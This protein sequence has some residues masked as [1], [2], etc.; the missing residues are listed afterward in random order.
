MFP[1]VHIYYHGEVTIAPWEWTLSVLYVVMLY[2]MFAR[3]KNLMLARA[4]EYRY[5]LWGLMAKLF[6]GVVFSL[7]YFYYYQGG[8]TTAYFYSAVAMRNM[9][10]EDPVEY[11]RQLFGDNSLRAW[12]AYTGDTAKPYQYVF[13]DNRTFAVLQFTSLLAILTFKSYLITTLLIASFSFYGVWACFR[14]FVSYYPQLMD[15]LAIGFLFMPS[16]VF[17]GSAILK[18]T[19]SFSAVCFWVHAVDEV[20]YKRR[21]VVK[22]SIIM[23]LSGMVMIVVKPYIFMVLLPATI[24]WLFY[25]RVVRLRSTLV[26]FVLIPMAAASMLGL[27]LLILTRL[28]DQLDKFALDGALQTIQ[29]TQQDLVNEQAYGANRFDVGQI[30]GTW[31]SVLSKFPVATNAALFR[32]YI[33]ESKNAVMMLSGLENLWVLMIAILAVVRAGP[34]FAVRTMVGIPILLM[35]MTFALLFSFIVGVTTPN[36]GALVRF[37]IPMVPFFISSLYI[38]VYMARLKRIVESKGLKFH[39]EGLRMGTAF[40]AGE[41][42][43]KQDAG[44]AGGGKRGG[45]GGHRQGPVNVNYR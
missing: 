14:T 10:F 26:K 15:K 33:W 13:F 38:I 3:T 11:L 12:S 20:F 36:F 23:V 43:A 6:G 45:L 31:S 32:P 7:I 27:S 42:A 16:T 19:F 44:R 1:L 37:K 40:M 39:L 24:M 17:W 4:P 9:A 8:D 21:D 18:D 25:F 28:G 22:N 34:F 2:I 30:D 29:V 35:S 41:G 5:Y